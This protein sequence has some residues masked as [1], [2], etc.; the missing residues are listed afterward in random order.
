MKNNSEDKNVKITAISHSTIKKIADQEGWSLKE[1]ISKMAKFFEKNKISP[2]DEYMASS[3]PELI[4]NLRL[5][6]KENFNRIHK[7]L[8]KIQTDYLDKVFGTLG[9]LQAN[10][11]N[12]VGEDDPGTLETSLDSNSNTDI[13]LRSLMSKL[14]RI[15][16]SF[17]EPVYRITLTEKEYQELK[18]KII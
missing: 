16:D 1:C 6:N 7:R 5:D 17:G 18:N 10:L 2:D 4:Q 13:V 11:F 8:T 12:P 15:P 9:T 3:I 14:V